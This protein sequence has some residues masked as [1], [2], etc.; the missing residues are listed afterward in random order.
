[1][2]EKAREKSL[3]KVAL[4]TPNV[5]NVI[6]AH[7]RAV[8]PDLVVI[9]NIW[10]SGSNVWK[11]LYGETPS[12]SSDL[13]VFFISAYRKRDGLLS[14]MSNVVFGDYEDPRVSLLTDLGVPV[15]DAEFTMTKT[16]RELDKYSQGCKFLFKGRKVDCWQGHDSVAATL[17]DYPGASHGHCRA[18]F[19]FTDGLVVLPNEQANV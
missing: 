18:A 15:A 19:S 2:I 3:T 4:T 1:M 5:A 13:D 7:L 9:P 16:G 14:L 17:N 12:P 8:A 11:H 6:A 10:F